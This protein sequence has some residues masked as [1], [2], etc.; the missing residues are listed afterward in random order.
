[1]E[2]TGSTGPHAPWSELMPDQGPWPPY[3][4]LSGLPVELVL[5]WQGGQKPTWVLPPP[6]VLTRSGA[7][8]EGVNPTIAPWSP[9]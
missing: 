3:S 9:H 4:L 6:Q 8:M 5:L 1:M 7:V 2:M